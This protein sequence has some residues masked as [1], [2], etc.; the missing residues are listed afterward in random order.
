MSKSESWNKIAQQLSK[1]LPNEDSIFAQGL[2]K[3]VMSASDADVGIMLMPVSADTY[4]LRLIFEKRLALLKIIDVLKLNAISPATLYV[5]RADA[6]AMLQTGGSASDIILKLIIAKKA[7]QQLHPDSGAS[8][9]S[10]PKATAAAPNGNYEVNKALDNLL[11]PKEDIAVLKKVAQFVINSDYDQPVIDWT[12]NFSEKQQSVHSLYGANV[13]KIQL[14]ALGAF[15]AI[16]PQIKEVYFTSID[17]GSVVEFEIKRASDP[18]SAMKERQ[19]SGHKSAR[20]RDRDR[21]ESGD[22]EDEP[23]KER[24]EE[25]NRWSLKFW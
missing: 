10:P 3:Q 16:V 5:N 25:R 14:D 21:D 8:V 24:G 12:F 2:L 4:E 6:K 1:E 13:E 23:K 15:V 9:A 11:L 20:N 18:V 19:R 22:E 17:G 7:A